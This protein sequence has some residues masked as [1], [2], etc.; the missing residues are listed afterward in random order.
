MLRGEAYSVNADV[1]SI[2][3]ILYEM[4]F[5]H[6]PFESSSI[7]ALIVTIDETYLTFDPLISISGNA[8]NLIT[9]CLQKDTR[10][11]LKWD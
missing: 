7:A 2:G 4:L 1:W 6:C 3:V 9:K 5:G 11:R 10:K 8:R